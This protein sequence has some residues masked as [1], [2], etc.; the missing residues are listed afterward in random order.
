MQVHGW[1]VTIT[2]VRRSTLDIEIRQLSRNGVLINTH[3]QVGVAGAALGTVST[4]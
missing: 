2:G 3:V 1:G 4:V